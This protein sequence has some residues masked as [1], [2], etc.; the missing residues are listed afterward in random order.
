[1]APDQLPMPPL[2][3]VTVFVAP[4]V[5]VT[6]KVVLVPAVLV[7]TAGVTPRTDTARGVTVTEAV[8]VVP[9]L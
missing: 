2:L 8:A 9:L 3:Q 4:P 5:T 7:A 6:L 1:M